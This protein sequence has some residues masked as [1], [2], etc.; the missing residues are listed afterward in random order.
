MPRQWRMGL[1]SLGRAVIYGIIDEKVS[2]TMA[3]FLFV[4]PWRLAA[5]AM[6][7]YPTS[8]SAI[9]ARGKGCNRWA[10][11]INVSMLSDTCHQ[12]MC[13]QQA[14]EMEKSPVPYQEK[15]PRGCFGTFVKQPPTR[16]TPLGLPMLNHFQQESH[17][18]FCFWSS[19]ATAWYFSVSN[20]GEERHQMANLR[21]GGRGFI[22][23]F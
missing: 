10:S 20:P 17:R 19:L 13:Y 2:E 18:P 11:S 4:V 3:V 7:L 12:N 15:G 22:G 14:A 9:R 1:S 5:A 23:I 6:P 8:P 21:R 16:V